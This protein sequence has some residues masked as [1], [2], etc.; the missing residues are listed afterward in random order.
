MLTRTIHRTTV[1]I[2]NHHSSTR[3]TT[4]QM[5]MGTESVIARLTS[6]G[7]LQTKDVK[8]LMKALQMGAQQDAKVTH[9]LRLKGV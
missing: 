7:L 6:S 8:H 2:H 5:S 3:S 9:G 1:V 4:R